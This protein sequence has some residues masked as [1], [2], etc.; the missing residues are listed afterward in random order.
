MTAGTYNITLEEGANY[1]LMLT[2]KDDADDPIDLTNFSGRMKIKDRIGGSDIFDCS[3][4]LTLGGVAG[5][6]SINIPHSALHDLGFK[7]GVYDLEV[8]NEYGKVYKVLRGKAKIIQ[9]VTD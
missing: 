5:T 2:W 4:Y 7:S 6:I 3:S 1:D 9:E 8:E